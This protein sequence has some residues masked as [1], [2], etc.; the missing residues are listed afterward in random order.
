MSNK[1]AIDER[2]NLAVRKVFVLNTNSIDESNLAYLK[3]CIS[4]LMNPSI[5]II[6]EYNVSNYMANS[7]SIYTDASNVV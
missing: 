1:F 5:L 3:T 2:I 4:Q 6:R 7:Y